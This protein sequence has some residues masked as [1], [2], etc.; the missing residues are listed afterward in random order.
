MLFWGFIQIVHS[1]PMTK[2]LSSVV[3]QESHSTGHAQR[4]AQVDETPPMVRCIDCGLFEYSLIRKETGALSMVSESHRASANQ[5]FHIQSRPH[6]VF[7]RRCSS[8]RQPDILPTRT[9]TMGTSI[10]AER[11]IHTKDRVC[12]ASPV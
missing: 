9:C 11:R 6:P 4:P 8:H 3:I 1:L 7:L 2:E 5:A 12:Y 10:N